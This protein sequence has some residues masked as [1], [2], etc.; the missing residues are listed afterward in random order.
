MPGEL[1][2]HVLRG[3]PVE[4][5]PSHR[6]GGVRMPNFPGGDFDGHFRASSPAPVPQ[7]LRRRTTHPRRDPPTP[8]SKRCWPSSPDGSSSE[9]HALLA[10]ATPEGFGVHAPR[11]TRTPGSAGPG[12]GRTPVIVHFFG[13]GFGLSPWSSVLAYFRGGPE[14]WELPQVFSQDSLMGEGRGF[15]GELYSK[16]GWGVNQRHQSL[17]R[18][19]ALRLSLIRGVS[20]DTT[21][22]GSNDKNP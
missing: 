18:I 21:G 8:G 4:R 22:R 12:H 9:R 1:R 2:F 16:Y 20:D 19:L 5:N 3:H 7:P 14:V 10:F 11:A 17:G 6:V 13:S 15:S